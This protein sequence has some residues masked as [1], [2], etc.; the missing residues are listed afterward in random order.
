MFEDT[1]L[2]SSK[3]PSRRRGLTTFVSLVLQAIFVAGLIVLPMLFTEAL[4]L[5]GL[6]R[7]LEIPAPPR[8]PQSETIPIVRQ[9]HQQGINAP[10][11]IRVSQN[12]PRSPIPTVESPAPFPNLADPSTFASNVPSGQTSTQISDVLN[13]HGTASPRNGS[14]PTTRWRVSGGVEQ[15]LLVHEVKPIYPGLARQVGVQG[16]V[17]LQAVIGKDGRIENLRVISGNPLLV[18]AAWDAVLQWR[19]RPYL[20]DGEPVEVET[21]ITVNFKAS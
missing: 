16:E 5:R 8:L 11:A 14:G 13:F 12:V 2:I 6:K 10:E 1:L 4:P 18:K 15:G 19:Y 21:Q 7:I 9:S 17:I 3:L 20:L